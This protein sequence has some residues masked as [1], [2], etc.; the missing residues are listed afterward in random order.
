MV[1]ALIVV[2]FGGFTSVVY[3]LISDIFILSGMQKSTIVFL[4]MAC[5]MNIVRIF[6]LH[7]RS[8]VG[9][10]GSRICNGSFSNLLSSGLCC[11]YLEENSSITTKEDLGNE[12][13]Y[14]GTLSYSI[15]DG[16]RL[17]LLRSERL[18][19]K[20]I[21]SVRTDFHGCGIGSAKIDQLAILP[22][23]SFGVTMAHYSAQNFGA[24]KYDR[25]WLGVRECIKLSLTFAIVVGLFKPT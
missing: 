7:C 19:F 3:N 24:K 21:R 11:L 2:I 16:F 15:S 17:Q 22:M 12:T 1:E 13:K 20:C 18:W 5:V 14:K 9:S 4:V 10:W 6:S 25:I 8:L 23:M